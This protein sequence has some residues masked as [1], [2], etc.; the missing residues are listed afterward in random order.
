MTRLNERIATPLPIEDAFDYLSDFANA[1]E[2]DPGTASA[3]RIG[4]GEVGVGTRYR[5]GVR[6]GKRIVPMEY[7]ITAFD[8]P[9]RVELAGTGSGISAVDTIG[10]EPGPD[11]GSVV[12]YSAD[13]R[14]QGLMRLVQPLLGGTFRRIAADAADGIRRTLTER[15][16]AARG[17]GGQR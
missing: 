8:R 5:L 6:Q 14:L 10:F 7:R 17:D 1:E 9:R 12:E 11:G 16:S 2:W 3:Q 15:A 13:I 4:S